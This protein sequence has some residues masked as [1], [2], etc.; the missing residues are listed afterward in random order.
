VIHPEEI[1]ADNFALL[2]LDE[3]NLPSPEI[4]EK[5]R[6]ILGQKQVPVSQGH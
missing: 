2:I 4:I 1:L 3:R 6:L 5:M